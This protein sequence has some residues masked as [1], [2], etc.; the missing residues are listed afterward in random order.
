VWH[1]SW[2]PLQER[3][4]FSEATGSCALLGKQSIRHPK[5]YNTSKASKNPSTLNPKNP[6]NR[7]SIIIIIII[8]NHRSRPTY[9]LHIFPPSDS[10]TKRPK[11]N[12]ALQHGSLKTLKTLNPH[13]P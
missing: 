11:K 7:L 9:M 2:G 5:P 1:V 10:F 8:V 12:Q 13:A 3:L 4:D 6:E